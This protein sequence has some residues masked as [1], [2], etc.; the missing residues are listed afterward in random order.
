MLGSSLMV[1]WR[2]RARGNTVARWLYQRWMARRDYEDLFGRALLAAVDGT[3][4]VWDVG[5][6]VGLYTGQ[7]LVRGAREVVCF[8]PAP[9]AVRDLQ[10]KFAHDARVLICAVALADSTGTAPFFADGAAPTNRLGSAPAS[11]AAR[12]T[13]DVPVRRGEDLVAEHKAPAPTMIKVDVEGYEWEVLKGLG[14]LLSRPELRAVFV[15]VHF[16]I[17]HERG[18]DRAPAEIVAL[19]QGAGFG[20]RWLDLS[21]LAATRR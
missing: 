17:L 12:R 7:F 2:N 1:T 4:V 8:E 19:L 9:A 10:G 16:S 21:H 3:A 18:L 14:T 13:V 11:S 20:V 15:E 6:N 5:A